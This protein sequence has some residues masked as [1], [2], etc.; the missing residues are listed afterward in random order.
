MIDCFESKSIC[1]HLFADKLGGVLIPEHDVEADAVLPILE[2]KLHNDLMINDY[3][4]PPDSDFI[5][6]RFLGYLELTEPPTCYCL[7][8][9]RHT[10]VS[11]RNRSIGHCCTVVRLTNLAFYSGQ[12]GLTSIPRI[13]DRFSFVL[14]YVW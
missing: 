4:I 12:D 2:T 13:G 8:L 14:L 11:C 6:A 3:I 1:P 9:P 10:R 5:L 7:E